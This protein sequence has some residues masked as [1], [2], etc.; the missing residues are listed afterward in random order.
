[1]PYPNN[2]A[3]ELNP[4]VKVKGTMTRV[5]KGKK[6]SARVGEGGERSYLYPTSAWPEADARAH[7]KAHGGT[8]EPAAKSVQEME[9]LDPKKNPMIPKED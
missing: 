1:M 8:F 3:C 7:C 5:H 2:H 9:H 4:S 6:Y